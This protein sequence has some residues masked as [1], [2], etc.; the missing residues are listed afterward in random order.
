MIYCAWCKWTT[1]QSPRIIQVPPTPSPHPP[2]LHTVDGANEPLPHLHPSRKTQCMMQMSPSPATTKVECRWC[3]WAL[4]HPH[5]RSSLTTNH[6][7]GDWYNI[8]TVANTNEPHPH[9]HHIVDDEK[10]DIG[11]LWH[12]P[13]PP[14]PPPPEPEDFDWDHTI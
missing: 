6:V 5:K 2:N 12:L 11:T 7:E 13:P 1:F 8:Y 3:N 9:L 10:K 14:P 4:P